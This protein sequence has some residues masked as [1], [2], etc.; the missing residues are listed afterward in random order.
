[1]LF[2]L[3]AGKDFTPGVKWTHE[4]YEDIEKETRTS[5]SKL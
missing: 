4:D 2:V 1:M 5:N 3:M